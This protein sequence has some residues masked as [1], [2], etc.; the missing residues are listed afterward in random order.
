MNKEQDN[1]GFLEL[2]AEHERICFLRF[3]EVS[4]YTHRISRMKIEGG[5]LFSRREKARRAVSWCHPPPGGSA[6]PG[7]SFWWDGSGSVGDFVRR[8]QAG[9]CPP[10]SWPLHSPP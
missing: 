3:L 10:A 1:V 2:I 7:K 4:D 6:G 9:P 8:G 5:G